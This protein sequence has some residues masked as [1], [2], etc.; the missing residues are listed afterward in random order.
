MFLLIQLI[1]TGGTIASLPDEK[2]DVSATLTGE[3]L[4]K[5]LGIKE[6][7]HINSA[8]TIGSYAFN[9]STLYEV[10]LHVMDALKKPDISSVVITHGTDTMEE[11]A[12]YLSLVTGESS[13]PIILTGAQLDPSY[14]YTDGPKNLQEAII[15]AKSLALKNFGPLIVFGGFIYPARDVTKIDTHLLQGFDAPNTGAIGRIDL[16]EVIIHSTPEKLEPRFNPVIPTPVAL[17]RLGVGMTGDELKRMVETYEG[18][19][20]EGFGRGN[21][22]PTI[23]PVVENLVQRN[24]PVLI[25]SRCP[26]GSVKPIYSKGGG[27]DLEKVGAIFMG[28]LSGIKA[29]ILLGV[30]LA[31]NLSLDEMKQTIYLLTKPFTN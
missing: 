8:V 13:K 31:N 11:T 4:L 10:A 1:T 3:T 15:A 17:I 12:F 29:R 28:N 2:G 23:L 18:V 7:I 27:K 22:H 26:R 25:T 19:V 24:I 21:A 14:S 16:D 30:M 5:H 6:N 9:Y 20:I